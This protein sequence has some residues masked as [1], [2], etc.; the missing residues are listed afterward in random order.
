MFNII[1]STKIKQFQYEFTGFN[2]QKTLNNLKNKTHKNKKDNDVVNWKPGSL[3][4]GIKK[5]RGM[6]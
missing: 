3:K 6:D 4:V 2:L 1:F 5:K